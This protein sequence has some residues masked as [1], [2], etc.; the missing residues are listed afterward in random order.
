MQRGVT[1]TDRK[2]SPVWR[3]WMQ[4]RASVASA[5]TQTPKARLHIGGAGNRLCASGA[6]PPLLPHPVFQIREP[7]RP[8]SV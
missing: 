7:V 4:T 3:N 6:L 2:L 1:L 8:G 5:L